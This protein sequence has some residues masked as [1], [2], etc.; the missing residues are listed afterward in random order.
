MFNIFSL[1][2]KHLNIINLSFY[3]GFTFLFSSVT[4]CIQKAFPLI[5]AI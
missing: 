4:K 3:K 5:K 2:D 1:S